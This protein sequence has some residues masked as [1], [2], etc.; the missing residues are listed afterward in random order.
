M[1][2][3]RILFVDDEAALVSLT[4]R[5]LAK[6]GYRVTGLTDPRRALELFRGDPSA[7]DAVVTDLSMPAVSGFDLA[8]EICQLRPDLPLLLMSGFVSERDLH[9]SIACGIREIIQKPFA[10]E[11]LAQKLE[12]LFQDVS[13]TQV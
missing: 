3:K 12:Q 2:S 4:V 7:F 10:I 1:Q 8:R 6:L 11:T 13:G 5:S 9:E